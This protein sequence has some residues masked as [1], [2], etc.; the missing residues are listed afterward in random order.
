MKPVFALKAK[1]L[2]SRGRFSAL[3]D[4]AARGCVIPSIATCAPRFDAA[5]T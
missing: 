3:W 2:V 5:E 4:G 1:Q